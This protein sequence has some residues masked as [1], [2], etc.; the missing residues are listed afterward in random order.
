M[1][2]DAYITSSTIST[3]GPVF[4]RPCDNRR[5]SAGEHPK[6]EIHTM[7]QKVKVGIIGLGAIGKIHADAYA[8][9]PDAELTALCDVDAGRLADITPQFNADSNQFHVQAAK[10]LAACRRECP[11]AATAAEGLTVMR[12]MDGVYKSAKSGQ[13]V[14]L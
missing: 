4:S 7:K 10:F 12:L 13:E 8:H 9:C 6:A 3:I 1:K 5:A 14:A 2:E 11:P